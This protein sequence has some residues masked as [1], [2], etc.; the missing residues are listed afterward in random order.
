MTLNVQVTTVGNQ[1]KAPLISDD[2]HE[3][4]GVVRIELAGALAARG[5]KEPSQSFFR[6][7]LPTI[8]SLRGS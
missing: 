3:G 5:A 1:M 2:T 6:N 8:G 4:P 7:V